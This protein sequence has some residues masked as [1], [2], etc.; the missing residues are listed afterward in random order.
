VTAEE[1]LRRIRAQ[2]ATRRK[3]EGSYDDLFPGLHLRYE[4]RPGLIMRGSYSTSIGRPNFGAVL[5]TTNVD[6]TNEVVTQNNTDIGPQSGRSFNLGVE[7]Y[8]SPAGIVALSFFRTDLNDMIF[9]SVS[10]VGSGQENG[11]GGE[12]AGFDLRTQ[13][14]GGSAKIQG[15]EFNY[16]Q[17]LSWLPGFW[18]SFSVFGNFTYLKT[19]GRYGGSATSPVTELAR[20]TPRSGNFGV[21]FARYGVDVQVRG[22]YKGESLFS[23]SA[24]PAARIYLRSRTNITLNLG[25]KINRH[26]KVYCDWS[27]IFNA[28]DPDYQYRKEQIRFN[29]PSGSRL[30]FGLRYTL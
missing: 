8:F 19:S 15:V 2:Y 26:F 25:Y 12:Y 10:T 24:N 6:F 13:E 20:F 14:N 18:K 17:Q 9:S 22:T 3:A 27:N 23:Y 16:R 5:P 1:S 30:D 7:K 28:F 4:P 29:T 21:A 11:F